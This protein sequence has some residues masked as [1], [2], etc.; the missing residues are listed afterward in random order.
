MKKLLVLIPI[1][2][3]CVT[4]CKI[5]VTI[6]GK[7]VVDNKKEIVCTVN[8]NTDNYK[9]VTKYTIYH[10]DDIADSVKTVEE[11]STDNNETLKYFEEMLNKSYEELSTKYGGYTY[12]V[13]RTDKKVTSNVKI[14]YSE[15]D[16]EKFVDDQPSLKP[17][18]NSENKFTVDGIKSIYTA[19]GATCE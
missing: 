15:I 14:D 6:N 11:I 10:T 7:D 18:L 5:N 1:V 16:M 9:L 4:G 3:L 12:S 19:L 13:T 8:K 2:L 17:Y